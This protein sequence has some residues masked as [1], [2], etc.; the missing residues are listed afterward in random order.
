MWAANQKLSRTPVQWF[1]HHFAGYV[2]GQKTIIELVAFPLFSPLAI[3]IQEFQFSSR[4]N[5]NE[6]SRAREESRS[7]IAKN[8]W[9]D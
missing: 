4:S 2:V 3:K 1:I 7:L 6:N 5:G 8:T 9:F